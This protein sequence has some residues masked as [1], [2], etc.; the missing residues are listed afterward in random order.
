MRSYPPVE[1]IDARIVSIRV[2]TE[3][4]DPLRADPKIAA[5]QPVAIA[6]GVKYAAGHGVEVIA[7]PLDPGGWTGRTAGASPAQSA[8][9]YALAK[10]VTLVAPAGDDGAGAGIVNYPAAYPG[11]ISVGAFD[12]N[13]VKAPFTSR[14]S[15]VT[16]TPQVQAWSRRHPL[17]D[18]PCSTARVRPV[19]WSRG[20]QP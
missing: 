15:Y 1:G 16:L 17:G 6:A 10:D 2:I 18:M 9:A 19:Q 7:L 11:V 20:W 12:S 5:R 8:I 4:S 14:R 13:V 3:A